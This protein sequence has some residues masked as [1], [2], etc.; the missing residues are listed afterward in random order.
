MSYQHFDN[1]S[2]TIY[3][4]LN[5]EY[6]DQ[7]SEAENDINMQDSEEEN[8]INMQDLN[9]KT[10]DEASQNM[11][12]FNGAYGPYFPNFTATMLFIWVTKHMICTCHNACRSL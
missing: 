6:F 10:C 7:Y 8:D 11:N 4:C 12:S 2:L 5:S 3:N 9:A 1:R